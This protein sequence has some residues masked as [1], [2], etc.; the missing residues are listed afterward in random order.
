MW[1]NIA[2]A[3]LLAFIATFVSTPWTMRIAKKLGAVDMPKD[4]RRVHNKPMPRLGGLAIIVGFV[5]SMIYLMFVLAIENETSIFNTS[6]LG[7]NLFGFFIGGLVLI[8]VCVID[9]VKQIKPYIKLIAQII[10]AICVVMSG[11]RIIQIDIP[12]LQGVGLNE[13]FSIVLTMGW[14]V[15]VTN[16]INLIDGLDGLATGVSAISAISLLIVF[17]L[18]AVQLQVADP[19]LQVAIILVT[20][21]AGALLGFL[22]FNF[23]P[24]KTFMGDAG[25]NFLGYS[26]AVISILGTAKT[27][28]AIVIA[29]PIIILAL[30]IFDTLFTMGRRI[31]SGKSI[32]Q[33]DRGHLHHRLMDVGFTHRQSVLL[34]YGITAVLGMFA[35][36][37]LDSG[38]WKAVSFGLILIAVIGIGYKSIFRTR[39]EIASQKKALKLAKSSKIKIMIIVGTRPEAIKM[40]PLVNKLK[41]SEKFEL[42]LCS[43]AQHRRILDQVFEVFNIAP[44]YDLNIMKDRQT[45]T[46]ITT[47]VLEGLY[48]IIGDEGPDM[49]LVNGNTTT[50]F[51]SS[52]AAFYHRVKI[53]YIEAGLRT[54][55][56]YSPYPEEINRRLTTVLSDAF[57]VSTEESKENLLKEN[58][59][60][61]NIFVT[62]NML[63]DIMGSTIKNSY[64]FDNKELQDLDVKNKKIIVV[65]SHRRE[66]VGNPL[67]NV[68]EAIKEI[69]NKHVNDV[70][71][72]YLVHVSPDIQYPIVDILKGISN[73]HLLEPQN[74][75]ETHNLINKSYM[76]ITDS[77]GIQ[78]ESAYLG[79]PTLVI[80][81][82][83]ENSDSLE[84]D[85]VKVI[86]F[87]KDD[88][89][90]E[91]NELISD[92]KEYE[93]R[94]KVIIKYGDGN[95][96][97]KIIQEIGNMFK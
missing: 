7:V 23:N 30:P 17:L 29:S 89:E 74:I 68:C 21:L 46:H 52:L 71:I 90:K 76:V 93:R 83:T 42:V 33:A 45:L 81:Q 2:I 28:T 86:G 22:P 5:V 85:I 92:K 87:E 82:E 36:I 77:T 41:E 26:L 72:V 78:E 1:G 96:A 54:Y 31:L 27:Y 16:A 97:D 84:G 95:A 55:N 34:L 58:I 20:A 24:A 47:G 51:A 59:S 37:L 61:D 75:V 79:K 44:D 6:M 4:E 8:T 65:T 57:F 13:A 39:G 19:A 62:G 88:I 94:S 32:M 15:G 38:A 35:V 12:F 11:T 50:A 14:I 70:E 60:K 56:K 10:A 80:R 9:D 3:F 67:N 25:A 63:V 66:I 18:S 48:E 69:A 73:V 43:T 64:K 53:G 40:M 91:I 49:I